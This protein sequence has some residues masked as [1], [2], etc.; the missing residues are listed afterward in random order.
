MNT[1]MVKRL[2]FK[3]WY[4]NRGVIISYLAAGIVALA[5]VGFAQGS[6]LFYAGSI[7][8]ITALIGLGVHLTMAT[9]INERKQKT[10]PFVMS[11]PISVV[12]YTFSK[13]L[14]NMLTFLVPWTALLIGSFL[15]IS[16]RAGIPNGII[17]FVV[18]LL[19]QIFLGYCFVLAVALVSESEGWT[20]GAIVLVN[21]FFNLFMYYLANVTPMANELGSV[22]A[23]WS[24]FSMQLLLLDLVFVL[25]ILGL[26]FFLQARKKDFI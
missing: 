20:I 4:F 10:L 19:M 26:T 22:Q 25:L 8:L 15:V 5:L 21:I 7:L 23:V 18:A 6:G 12:E 9:V 16:S 2:T 17:P 13:I 3:D 11:L 24:P 1:F 14:A